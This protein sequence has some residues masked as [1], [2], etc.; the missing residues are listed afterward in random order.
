MVRVGL[1]CQ[2]ARYPGAN[3]CATEA[4]HKR[5]ISFLSQPNVRWRLGSVVS[6]AI[7]YLSPQIAIY[8]Y[9]IFALFYFFVRLYEEPTLPVWPTI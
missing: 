8:S 9:G 4:R 3:A 6:Q 1:C 5:T 2:R 7:Y